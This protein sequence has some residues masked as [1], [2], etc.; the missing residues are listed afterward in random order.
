MVVV[1]VVLFRWLRK[2]ENRRR[3]ALCVPAVAVEAVTPCSTLRAASMSPFALKHFALRT[4][5]L[6]LPA[7]I[8]STALRLS[9]ACENSLA[10]SACV[11]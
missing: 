7:S 9:S 4:R 11:R 6:V 3:Q 1:V 2:M 10:C 8:A 5:A